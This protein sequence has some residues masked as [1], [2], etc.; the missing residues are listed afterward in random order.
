VAPAANWL[1]MRFRR[2]LD[3]EN[4]TEALSDAAELQFGVVSRRRPSASVPL[5][6]GGDSVQAD[7]GR[8]QMILGEPRNDG[9]R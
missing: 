6:S 7:L 8:T 9:P 1:T 2:A 3:R 4:V 5:Y